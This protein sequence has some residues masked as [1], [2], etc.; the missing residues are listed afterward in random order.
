MTSGGIER[1]E[2]PSRPGLARRRATVGCGPSD[3][4][5]ARAIGEQLKR[6]AA[7]ISPVPVNAFG[8]TAGWKLS[9]LARRTEARHLRGQ[10]NTRQSRPKVVAII[11]AQKWPRGVSS[12]AAKFQGHCGRSDSG[13]RP[14]AHSA[15]RT[16]AC[17]LP[18]EF[19][20]GWA[21]ETR[22]RGPEAG[23]EAM[24]SLASLHTASRTAAAAAPRA[25]MRRPCSCVHHQ[26]TGGVRPNARENDQI[27]PSIAVRTARGD[28][29]RPRHPPV[30]P[31][32]RQS[33]KLHA[34]SGFIWGIPANFEAPISFR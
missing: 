17:K 27:S 5:R 13:F 26:T 28:G 7:D 21:K 25:S 8:L 34:G 29:S 11:E 1:L 6:P 20:P 3:R 4:R 12:G 19:S 18:R 22:R 24:G 14:P 30:L 32:R 23:F 31:E 15:M 10:R 2:P 9:A 16:A 33:A